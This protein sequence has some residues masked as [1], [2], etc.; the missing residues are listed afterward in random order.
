MSLEGLKTD[1]I[2]LLSD[3]EIGVDGLLVDAIELLA[4]VP[5]SIT[6]ILPP[7][8]HHYTRVEIRGGDFGT[9][10]GEVW[11]DEYAAE[12]ISWK[13][14]SIICISP[15]EPEPGWLVV[16]VITADGKMGEVQWEQIV[17]WIEA[18]SPAE[19]MPGDLVQVKTGEKIKGEIEVFLDSEKIY[20][21]LIREKEFY[22]YMPALAP[23]AYTLMVRKLGW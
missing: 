8:G 5:V 9:V 23:R 19:I 6:S 17:E 12:I 1:A 20:P 14:D 21:F 10:Q 3:D 22:F 11:F 13:K 2:V 7:F 16:T 4:T 15:G 18:V